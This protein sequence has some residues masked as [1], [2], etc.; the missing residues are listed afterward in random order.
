[1]PNTDQRDLI[2]VV[3]IVVVVVVVVDNL[4]FCLR[5]DRQTYGRIHGA[6]YTVAPQQKKYGVFKTNSATH[7]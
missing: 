5:T 2:D 4:K 7:S 1:M 6:V 3:V